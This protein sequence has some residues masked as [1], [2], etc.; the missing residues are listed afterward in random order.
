VL[1]DLQVQDPKVLKDLEVH[2]EP[3]VVEVQQEPKVL[4]DLVEEQDL[5]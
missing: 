4:K 2:K 1:K 5:Q 3:K